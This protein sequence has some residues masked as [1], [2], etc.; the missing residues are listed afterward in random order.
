MFIPPTPHL[1]QF[2]A[3]VS[4]LSRGLRATVIGSR[5]G[6]SAVHRHS[7]SV[8]HLVFILC[9]HKSVHQKCFAVFLHLLQSWYIVGQIFSL[10]FPCNLST[11]LP[12]FKLLGNPEPYTHAIISLISN[13]ASSI[14][15]AILC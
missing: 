12:I 6:F 15:T 11:A 9:H 7:R 2:S 4:P 3:T 13:Q 14:L 10:S 8:C 1:R 5:A